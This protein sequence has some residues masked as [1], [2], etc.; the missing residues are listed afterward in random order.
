MQPVDA[1]QNW[2]YNRTSTGQPKRGDEFRVVHHVEKYNLTRHRMVDPAT[3]TMR[4]YSTKQKKELEEK[5]EANN[6]ELPESVPVQKR[7]YWEAWVVG[8]VVLQSGLQSAQKDFCYQ[9]MTGYRERETGYWTAVLKLMLDPQRYANRM[10]SL[11]MSILATGAK[12]GVIYETGTF[13]NQKKALDD[14]GRWNAAIELNPGAVAKG[15]LQPRQP[16]TMPPD[17]TM[18]MQFAVASIRDATGVNIEL[19]G[20]VNENE[21]GVVEDM[22]AKAGLTIL[23]T[24][25]DAMRLY[26]KRQGVIWAEFVQRFI[27]D[28]RLIRILGASGQQFVPLIRDKFAM[29]Y[30]VV[31]DESPSSRDVKTRTWLALREL[32]PM[33]QG[34]GIFTPTMLDYTPLPESL[35][36][37]IK[38][39]YAQM[40]QQKQQH[41]PAPPPEVQ[42]AQMKIQ[43]EQ[44]M[45]QA[46]LQGQQQLDQAKMQQQAAA[47]QARQAADVAIAQHKAQLDAALEQQRIRGDTQMEQMRFTM[48]QHTQILTAIINAISKVETQ[49][50]A[51]GADAGQQFVTQQGYPQQ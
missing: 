22:K 4:E 18:L 34:M 17:S 36:T 27:S 25:F 20:Q 8:G 23:A 13:A 46:K 43:A 29:D 5:A 15:A 39:Q 30:D 19:L 51:V 11:M 35:I 2:K 37:E 40:Q 48:Q 10:V 7:T 45:Q 12:G 44:G 41:P 49:R 9:A 1:S 3:G 26:R 31:V 33:L 21:T 47:D 14:W 42:V 6:V 16:V 32:F 28:G 24:L 50:V 38:Q